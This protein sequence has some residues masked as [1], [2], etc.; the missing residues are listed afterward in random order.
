MQ[1]CNVAKHVTFSDAVDTKSASSWS[2]LRSAVSS[3]YD[4]SASFVAYDI[5]PPPRRKD[6]ELPKIYRF[7]QSIKGNHK[8]KS[9]RRERTEA[10]PPEL[11][12]RLPSA[13][14]DSSSDEGRLCGSTSTL[15]IVK[16]IANRII[17]KILQMKKMED[18][19][20]SDDQAENRECRDQTI[21]SS[22]STY[23]SDGSIR[24]NTS[25]PPGEPSQ[26]DATST[27][28]NSRA[29]NTSLDTVTDESSS[30]PGSPARTVSYCLCIPLLCGCAICCCFDRAEPCDCRGHLCGDCCRHGDCPCAVERGSYFVKGRH[31]SVVSS[32]KTSGLRGGGY[33]N[34]AASCSN[35]ADTS[36]ANASPTSDD[37]TSSRGAP[38]I[39]F[40]WLRL[41]DRQR[42]ASSSRVRSASS[43]ANGRTPAL[44][45]RNAKRGH[46]TSREIHIVSQLNAMKREILGTIE[47]IT[48][49][50]NHAA[51][52]VANIEVHAAAVADRSSVSSN[53][54]SSQS[55]ESSHEGSSDNSKDS[56]V[57]VTHSA[58]KPQEVSAS[59]P[60]Q[61]PVCRK[62]CN[63][64]LA[65]VSRF[66]MMPST[67]HSV[68]CGS[69]FD[70]TCQP[71]G[72]V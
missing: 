51:R 18:D 43:P 33:R 50:G 8:Q 38:T 15:P 9:D 5:P 68:A 67:S 66:K 61:S 47:R 22:T 26:T 39:N 20:R 70:E 35:T 32:G 44:H 6:F 11:L 42:S 14:S 58:S 59:V 37:A 24:L 40:S 54:G 4:R 53:S 27:G 55:H 71:W 63:S 28:E 60:T 69:W 2:S 34:R 10:P 56:V 65:N 3:R 45:A 36:R 16:N 46:L 21:A 62:S 23:G 52:L 57:H 12:P 31:S 72:E 13:F 49:L 41:Q 29:T 7:L 25:Q 19:A 48:Q 17:R 1:N 30:Q 64:V